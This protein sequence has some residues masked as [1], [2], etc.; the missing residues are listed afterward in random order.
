MKKKGN[1]GNLVIC[2]SVFM[3]FGLGSYSTIDAAPFAYIP[4]SDNNNVSVIDTATNPPRVA[5][6][7]LAGTNPRGVVSVGKTSETLT[8]ITNFGSDNVSVIRT[9]SDALTTNVVFEK[10]RDISIGRDRKSVV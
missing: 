9:F 8:F 7:V 6:T 5:A 4:N 10:V 3:L 1:K 2:L